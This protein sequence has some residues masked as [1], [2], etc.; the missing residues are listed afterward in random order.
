MSSVPGWLEVHVFG[1]NDKGEGIVLKLPDGRYGVIDC[2]FRGRLSD[3]TK[4][5]ML[6]FL[7]SK[8]VKRLAFACLTHP[9]E[10]HYFGL[11]EILKNVPP[12]EFWTP[13]CL[14]PTALRAIALA[15]SKAAAERDDQDLTLKLRE[16]A[17]I[18]SEWR[19]LEKRRKINSCSRKVSSCS[20]LY[21]VPRPRNPA[22][23]IEAFS[24]AG[25]EIGKYERSLSKCFDEDNQIK[26]RIPTLKHNEISVGLLIETP[27]FSIVLGGD[28]EIANWNYAFKDYDCKRFEKVRLIK[29]SHH[30]SKTGFHEQIWDLLKTGHL[31]TVV[32]SHSPSALPEFSMISKMLRHSTRLF[33][34]SRSSLPLEVDVVGADVLAPESVRAINRFFQMDERP[35]Q[36]AAYF[37][38]VETVQGLQ[39]GRCSFYFDRSGECMIELDGDGCEVQRS[40]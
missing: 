30:G 27:S 14:D 10:D 12:D 2:C 39:Y 32:T 16:L 3:Y 35:Q 28:V 38:D 33:S 22:F 40:V 29:A 25:R 26:D 6:D 5:P 8:G 1:S 17:E 37:E 24:P 18:Y 34:T 31:D 23:S 4:H 20:L 9:H 7:Q 19:R 36:I 15:G 11:S 13:A 21:P